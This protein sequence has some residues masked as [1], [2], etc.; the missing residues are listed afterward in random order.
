MEA[1]DFRKR[2]REKLKG[3]WSDAIVLTLVFVAFTAIV[4]WLGSLGENVRLSSIAA[5]AGLFS[6]IVMPA[7]KY[8]LTYSY[9]KLKNGEKVHPFDFLNYGFSN[10]SRA[11]GVSWNI[12][13]KLIWYFVGLTI[14]VCALVFCA[15]FGAGALFVG[16]GKALTSIQ[17]GKMQSGIEMLNSIG[18]GLLILFF[19]CLIAVIVVS[20]FA[21]IKRLYYSL[22]TFIAIENPNMTT[23][24]A[25][26]KSREIM[27]GKRG[28]YFYLTL[29]FIGW[30]FLAGIVG[31]IS[32]GILSFIPVISNIAGSVG[33]LVLIPYIQISL[34]EFY[35]YYKLGSMPQQPVQ[36]MYNNIPQ[37]PAQPMYNNMP[38]Q[39]VQPMYNNMPQQPEQP[40][41]NNMP[42]QPVQPMYNNTPQQPVQPMYN[43]MPQQPVQPMNNNVP[44]QPV[45]PMNNN[46]Q[47]QPIQAVYNDE[48][49]MQENTT[50]NDSNNNQ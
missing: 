25:V 2:A 29:T 40:M 45:Q 49:I 38:Q 35:D 14:L 43:N 10:F 32:G 47:E 28:K 18:V 42:Q 50:N 46:V 37:Q 48:Q 24:Q 31:G 5:M 36:P 7:I 44:Q 1:K 33:M 8:G 19:V 12:F 9:M 39:P 20:I 16:S 26:E 17:T 15:A 21:T 4:E 27:T 23:K 3:K 6:M 13:L 11:W 34:L 41:N 30:G 22:S